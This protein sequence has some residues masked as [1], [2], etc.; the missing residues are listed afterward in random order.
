[1]VWNPDRAG[2]I[3]FPSLRH[4]IQPLWGE[5]TDIFVPVPALL[6]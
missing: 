1:M 3:R 2:A 4:R 5:K 6:G